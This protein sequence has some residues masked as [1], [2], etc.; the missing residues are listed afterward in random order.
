MIE[1]TSVVY[2]RAPTDVASAWP[3]GVPRRN[4]TGSPVA[5]WGDS[6][7][8][9]DGALPHSTYGAAYRLI[10]TDVRRDD[11]AR[12][13]ESANASKHAL[14]LFSSRPASRPRQML[15]RAARSKAAGFVVNGRVLH[16]VIRRCRASEHV[17]M[18][19]GTRLGTRRR[20]RADIKGSVTQISP[21][22]TRTIREPEPS[23][24]A[25]LFRRGRR[26]R[27]TPTRPDRP[28]VM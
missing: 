28:L 19:Q 16:G 5:R 6:Q 13:A 11:L 22:S 2:R 3:C 26:S 10:I 7:H 18:G 27:W 25:A 24:C 15:L 1:A 9:C 20:R 14:A 8:A 4:R 17:R 12:K 23:R 21:N